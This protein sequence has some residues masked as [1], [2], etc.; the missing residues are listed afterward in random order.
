MVHLS[1]VL[2]LKGV[3]PL[4]ALF[5]AAR[6]DPK[7]YFLSYDINELWKLLNLKKEGQVR[8]HTYRHVGM[9]A[10]GM[11]ACGRVG[12]RHLSHTQKDKQN[13]GARPTPNAAIQ[14]KKQKRLAK[15]LRQRQQSNP[16]SDP[17]D[18]Q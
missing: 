15:Q 4:H 5:E 10:C 17:H 8:T 16:H 11:W 18:P 9:S 14:H 1:L 6:D 3:G 13:S 12:S 2:V 7:T